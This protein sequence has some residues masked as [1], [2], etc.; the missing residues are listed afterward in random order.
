LSND[1]FAAAEQISDAQETSPPAEV[2][3]SLVFPAIALSAQDR[4]RGRL[5]KEA[6]TE[7]SDTISA[8]A[9]Q[10]NPE[11]H[12]KSPA[13]AFV[14]VR[15]ELD[16][17]AIPFAV[18]EIN[19]RFSGSACAMKE[20]SGL[21]ALSFLADVK[22]E[23]LQKIVLL[24]VTS[25]AGGGIRIIVDRARR[26][27]PETEIIFLDLSSRQLA[28]PTSRDNFV[29]PEIFTSFARFA[30]ALG[31]TPPNTHDVKRVRE[32]VVPA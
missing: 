32:E 31:R 30:D 20:A 6:F 7:L 17:L 11:S 23:N 13:I 28:L 15:G 4:R 2:L 24:T 3:D 21:T 22:H 9:T 14:P 12:S 10:T 25:L 26:L 16:V 5:D 19:R 8:V 27:F 18:S 1:V 29:A